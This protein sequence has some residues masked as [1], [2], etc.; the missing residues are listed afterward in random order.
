MGRLKTG[1]PPRLDGGTIDWG[2]GGAAARRR[3]AD[4]V[5][6]HD[7]GDHDAADPCG[8]TRTTAETHAI[9]TA[10]LHRSADVFR[11]DREP[12]AALLPVD[13][14]Q[15]GPL[16]RA[17]RAPDL[18]RA[19]GARRHHGLSERHLDLACPRTCRPPWW[20]RFPGWRRRGSSG[21]A[22]PSSTITSIRAS[23]TPTLECRTA[24]GPVP[25]RPDQRHD[26]LRGSG[27]AGPDRR[28]ECGALR[29]RERRRH[30]VADRGLYRG[31]D[32]R[33]GDPRR[34]RAVPDVHL[35][36]GISPVAPCRQCRS[37][38]D[39]ARHCARPGRSRSG[40]PPSRPRRGGSRQ[41]RSGCATCR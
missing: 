15:G 14:G 17:R 40:A 27:R 31:D 36:G 4:A 38:A 10:N 13:R 11:A 23:S 29:R 39:A 7:G 24:P 9:I 34:D 12:R 25:G 3:A 32:R 18:P 33:P 16:R 20:R 28:A 37:A 6:V 19:G 8:I 30:R 22:T 26:G 41:R 21:R 35:A 5:L 2:C 1:T